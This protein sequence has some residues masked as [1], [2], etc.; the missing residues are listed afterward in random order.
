[1]EPGRGPFI[2]KKANVMLLSQMTK[3]ER[4]S[5]KRMA[6]AYNTA[7]FFYICVALRRYDLAVVIA[8]AI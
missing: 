2:L 1:M 3:I 7:T 5:P 4:L 6:L 8:V